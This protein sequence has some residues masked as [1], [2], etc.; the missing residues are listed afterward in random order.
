[1]LNVKD[2]IIEQLDLLPEIVLLQLYD[3]IQILKRSALKNGNTHSIQ[4]Q[5][6]EDDPLIGLF[7]GS[8]DL[9]TRAEEILAEGADSHSGWTW[10][11]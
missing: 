4:T 1:M 9:A 10:K 3:L 5:P 2:Q 11:S 6:A 7:T 8:P